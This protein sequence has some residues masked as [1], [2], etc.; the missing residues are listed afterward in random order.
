MWKKGLFLVLSGLFI[1]LQVFA[2]EVSPSS[3]AILAS[4]FLF[5]VSSE[6]DLNKQN[7]WAQNTCIMLHQK[8]VAIRHNMPEA[9]CIAEDLD[10]S[11]A[12]KIEV[13]K[14]SGQIRYYFRFLEKSDG[15]IELTVENWFKEDDTDFDK[16]FWTIEPDTKEVQKVKIQ[17][18][19]TQVHDLKNNSV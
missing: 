11:A 6:I 18:H 3:R 9:V 4:G 14:K 15:G 13:S 5:S 8:L 1:S 7:T 17:K 2:A 19:L 12:Q 10:T 16:A